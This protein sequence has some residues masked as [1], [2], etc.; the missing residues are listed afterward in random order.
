MAVDS[1]GNLYIADTGN[2]RI[3]K[4]SNGV[5]TT[6][7]GDGTYAFGGDNGP[8]IN[9]QFDYP[10]GVAV[11]AAGNFY[12]ADTLNHRIRKVS[13]GVITT[14]AGTGKPG[15]SGEN[16]AAISS[17]LNQP[18]GVAVNTS[19]NLLIADTGNNRVRKV[20]NGVISQDR[21]RVDRHRGG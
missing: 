12:V 13:G 19:G 21:K 1:T 9:A 17:Q 3:R 4:V 15:F 5:I 14:V 16:A 20:F 8:A 2:G 11:D 6:V 7:A 18:F 10:N